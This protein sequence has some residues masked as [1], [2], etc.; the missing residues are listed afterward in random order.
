MHHRLCIV[1]VVGET[2]LELAAREEY[3]ALH[4]AQRKAHVLGDFG[5]FVALHMHAE[6]N[7]VVVGKLADGGGNFGGAV[8][9][10]RT[11]DAAVLAKI[12]VVE[13]V[14]GVHNC[15]RPDT[16]TVIVDEDVAHD[17]ENPALEVGV[18]GILVFIVQRLKGSILKQVVGVVAVAGQHVGEVEHVGLEVHEVRLEF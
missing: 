9:A 3:A 4:R 1:A 5:I 11:F 18:L 12:E 14:G 17:G 16:T 8:A 6:R 7:A 10:F 2:F 15:G 13:V